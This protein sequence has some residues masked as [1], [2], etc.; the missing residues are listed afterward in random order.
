MLSDMV[1]LTMSAVAAILVFLPAPRFPPPVL[2]SRVFVLDW[3]P[4]PALL[5]VPY[6]I[7]VL[8]PAS[9]SDCFIA[10]AHTSHLICVYQFVPSHL[11]RGSVPY[12]HPTSSHFP[13]PRT[14]MIWQFM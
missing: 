1:F 4:I 2:F 6:L 12:S 14:F 8:V 5:A 10:T 7:S 11:Y 13:W 3:V 9:S